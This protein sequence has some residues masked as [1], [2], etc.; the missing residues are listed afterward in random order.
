MCLWLYSFFDNLGKMILTCDI[1]RQSL[2]RTGGRNRRI[3]NLNNG[4]IQL[5]IAPFK[6]NLEDEGQLYAN[7]FADIWTIQDQRPLFQFLPAA[8]VGTVLCEQ[9]VK[10]DTSVTENSPVLCLINKVKVN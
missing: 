9:E 4:H 3:S 6:V 2:I 1:R 5:K 7:Y 10:M 8:Y